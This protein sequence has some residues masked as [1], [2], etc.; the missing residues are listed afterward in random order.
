MKNRV[1]ITMIVTWLDGCRTEFPFTGLPG[2]PLSIAV[3]LAKDMIDSAG[4]MISFRLPNT[5]KE[6]PWVRVT[7]GHELE[8]FPGLKPP[9]IGQGRLF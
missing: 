3:E 9:A 8:W 2:A 5:N 4:V 7:L 6:I 1:T